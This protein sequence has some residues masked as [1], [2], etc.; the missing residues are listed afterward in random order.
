MSS[1][2]WNIVTTGNQRNSGATSGAR[3]AFIQSGGRKA[4]SK[5]KCTMASLAYCSSTSRI[6]PQGAANR[7]VPPHWFATR[8]SEPLPKRGSQA[9][10]SGCRPL[11]TSAQIA[12]RNGEPAHSAPSIGAARMSRSG[13]VCCELNAPWL[14]PWT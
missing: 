5:V 2:S 11:R 7:S 4:E 3:G 6:G 12:L 10:L 13:S 9:G 14:R 1:A 8:T